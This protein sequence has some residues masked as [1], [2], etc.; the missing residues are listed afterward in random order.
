MNFS[1]LVNPNKKVVNLNKKIVNPNKNINN[2]GNPNKD[3]LNFLE[4]TK[5]KDF[6]QFH[7]LINEHLTSC[8][9]HTLVMTHAVSKRFMKTGIILKVYYFELVIDMLYSQNLLLMYTIDKSVN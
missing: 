4:L 9:T 2:L 3:I 8:L 7:F 6:D 5:F 1:N